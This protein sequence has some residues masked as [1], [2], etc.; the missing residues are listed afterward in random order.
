MIN[1]NIAF[2]S[3]YSIVYVSLAFGR[4]YQLHIPAHC[5]LF[6]LRDSVFLQ[7]T[8]AISVS[9]S[10]A[11]NVLVTCVRDDYFFQGMFRIPQER[12]EW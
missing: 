2:F 11:G 5:L 6:C 3:P 12:F 9:C 1:R 7:Y 10:R 8:I 4:M